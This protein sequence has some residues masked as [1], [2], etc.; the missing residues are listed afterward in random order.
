M[1]IYEVIEKYPK[2][3]SLLLDMGV[4]GVENDIV[5]RAF[6]KRTSVEQL[7]KAL[8]MD[9]YDLISKMEDSIE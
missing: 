6:G 1:T 8:H 4:K 3:R 5:L 2:I 7:A 9:V